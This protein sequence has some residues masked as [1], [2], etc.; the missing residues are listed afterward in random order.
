M[1]SPV[2]LS[3]EGACLLVSG[4]ESDGGSTFRWPIRV[5]GQSGGTG[6]GKG[7]SDGIFRVIEW[8]D[9]LISASFAYQK[10]RPRIMSELSASMITNSHGK[11]GACLFSDICRVQEPRDIT[12]RPSA[13]TIFR[14]FVVSDLNFV[15]TLMRTD[16]RMVE[17]SAPRSTKA[18]VGRIF[19]PVTATVF[20]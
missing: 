3:G 2:A 7:R 17:M 1:G 16:D 5:S 14:S 13:R 11:G 19:F 6:S 9:R 15:G 12:G 20:P 18:L 8:L 4:F 10:S